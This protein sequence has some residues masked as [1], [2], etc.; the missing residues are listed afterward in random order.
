MV[1]LN[2]FSL[3]TQHISLL[4]PTPVIHLGYVSD[5]L[6]N[7]SKYTE[8]A[9]VPS[10]SLNTYLV[11]DPEL[12]ILLTLLPSILPTLLPGQGL[13]LQAST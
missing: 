13:L 6:V 2:D 11:S 4:S 9:A 3:K 5:L 12:N 10:H 1:I 8:L 7:T